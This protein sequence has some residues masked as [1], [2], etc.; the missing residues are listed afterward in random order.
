M[1]VHGLT[2][3]KICMIGKTIIGKIVYCLALES[4]F[5]GLE[6]KLQHVPVTR[7][8]AGERESNKKAPDP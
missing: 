8:L 4:V 1:L 6:A 5:R 7:L 2:L 3:L